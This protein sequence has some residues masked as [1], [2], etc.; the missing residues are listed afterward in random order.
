M[1]NGAF[2]HLR[3]RGE[4]WSFKEAATSAS[5][6]L[7]EEGEQALLEGVFH[8]N[9]ALLEFSRTF[10]FFYIFHIYINI[11]EDFKRHKF[12]TDFSFTV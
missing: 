7:K 1:G 5:S 8:R 6:E 3:A 4:D 12:D 2:D 9:T 11:R 10:S